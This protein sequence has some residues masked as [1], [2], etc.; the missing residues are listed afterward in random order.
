MLELILCDVDFEMVNGSII[1]KNYTVG[2]IN[3]DGFINTKDITILSRGIAGGYGVT[4]TEAADV[5]GD[6]V[7]NTKDITILSRYIAG[8]YGVTL[9]N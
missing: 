5:N 1:V 9:G 2:D 4:L 6:G 3:D 7:T 8:G